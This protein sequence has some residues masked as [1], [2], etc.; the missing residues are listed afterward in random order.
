[1]VDDNRMPR[2][3]LIGRRKVWDVEEVQAAFKA[4]PHDMQLE[5]GDAN[6]WADFEGR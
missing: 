2:P 6:T 5:D 4:L 1:M 3:K